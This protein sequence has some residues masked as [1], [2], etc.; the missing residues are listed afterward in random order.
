MQIIYANAQ[1]GHRKALVE[2]FLECG[3]GL[4]ELVMETKDLS[5]NKLKLGNVFEIVPRLHEDKRGYFRETYNRE[6]FKKLGITDEFVQ[7]NHSYSRNRGTLRGL[8]FQLE[9]MA[10]A[11]LVRVI[12]G[13]VFDVAVDIQTGS[14]NYGKWV[15]VTL[16]REM[17]NQ[18][19][20]PAGFAHGF[21]TLEDDTEVSYK[22]SAHY[23]AEHDRTIRYDDPAIGIEWPDLGAEFIL[24]TKDSGA[25]SLCDI[26][27]SNT[28]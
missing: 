22:V 6:L 17:G 27:E 5:F 24:S 1:I 19:Y 11:K 18:L 13:A 16:T 25:C 8:H 2:P 23:S 7:D 4:I 9:P 15:G 10:Q 14:P 26:H 12:R 3:F 21:L 20:V 28:V